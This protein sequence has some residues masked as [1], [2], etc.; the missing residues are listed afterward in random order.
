M[1]TGGVI[2]GD[3][4]T[5]EGTGF[6]LPWEDRAADGEPEDLDDTEVAEAERGAGWLRAPEEAGFEAEKGSMEGALCELCTGAGAAGAEAVNF[7]LR[8]T[9][10]ADA[11]G[12]KVGF[13][14]MFGVDTLGTGVLSRVG[15]KPDDPK[16]NE[17]AG[18]A[19]G[20]AA[21][22]SVREVGGGG[23]AKEKVAAPEP[24]AALELSEPLENGGASPATGPDAFEDEEPKEN[25]AGAPT[26]GG[27]E[28]VEAGAAGGEGRTEAGATAAGASSF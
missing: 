12:G 23:G 7:S 4:C 3:F 6:G 11:D 1:A 17:A 27:K 14:P 22:V 8:L 28:K 5:S 15:L 25:T 19:M 16:E 24:G 18:G 21:G 13:I 20:E 9:L 10:T 26:A 2:L